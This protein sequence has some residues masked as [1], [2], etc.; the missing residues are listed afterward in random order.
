MLWR[1]SSFAAPRSKVHEQVV[2]TNKDNQDPIPVSRRRHNSFG[3][4][5]QSDNVPLVSVLLGDFFDQLHSADRAAAFV[6]SCACHSSSMVLVSPAAIAE[7]FSSYGALKMVLS[8][9]ALGP[10]QPG[11]RL[12]A[13]H[14]VVMV[15]PKAAEVV[16][17]DRPRH[18]VGAG[19]VIVRALCPPGLSLD[20]EGDT[21]GASQQLEGHGFAFDGVSDAAGSTSAASATYSECSSTAARLTGTAFSERESVAFQSCGIGARGSA[22][23]VVASMVGVAIVTDTDTTSK[24]AAASTANAT[25]TGDG[26]SSASAADARRIAVKANATDIATII[27]GCARGTPTANMVASTSA[28]GVASVPDITAPPAA[29]T[30]ASSAVPDA[31]SMAGIAPTTS[32]VAVASMADIDNMATVTGMCVL[33]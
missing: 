16:L 30:L 19:K 14:I 31:S 33:S 8:P 15:S 21:S 13:I 7:H 28:A 29:N 24:A 26:E 22:N 27:A 11:P 5:L 4:Q 12:H 23:N 2:P 9:R 1:I 17:S 6:A 25:S 3:R 10:Q 18:R 32:V 20:C